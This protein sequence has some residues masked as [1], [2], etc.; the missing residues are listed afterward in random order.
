MQEGRGA[1]FA[2]KV[3]DRMI[4]QASGQRL[5]TFDAYAQM[6]LPRDARRYDA[7]GAMARLLGI[8]APLLVLT[9]NPDK[10]A[11]IAAGT[12]LAV[13]GA[14][15]LESAPQPYNRHYLEAKARSGHRLGMKSPSAAAVRAAPPRPGAAF[16]PYRLRDAPR[17][18]H[19]ATYFLPVRLGA[20]EPSWFGLHAYFDLDDA[21]ERVV[22]GLDGDRGAVPLARVQHERLLERFVPAA[23]A[24]EKKAWLDV[25]RCI[26]AHGSGYAAFVP[27]GGFDARLRERSG[28]PSASVALLAH[29]LR[30]RPCR[31]VARSR[32]RSGESAALAGSLE[33]AG[34]RVVGQV[35]LDAERAQAASPRRCALPRG[36]ARL[37]RAARVR[38]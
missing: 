14:K 3:R 31:W 5:T 8:R 28:D 16:E 15:P 32:R 33:R 10:L 19:L 34:A 29:H 25:A 36:T 20:P 26:A 18:L 21:C 1:G 13:A 24:R 17:F 27:S 12:G 38:R 23:R 4:V 37:H 2:A 11:G 6:G 22:L 35:A 7:V 30:G 9:N